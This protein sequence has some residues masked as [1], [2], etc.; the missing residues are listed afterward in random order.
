MMPSGVASMNLGFTLFLAAAL[1]SG[2]PDW[3]QGS[4]VSLT[5][6]AASVKPAGPVAPGELGMR[7][8][9]GTDDPGRI[10][11]SRA[12]L[13]DL[14]CRA[15]DVWPDQISGPAWIN[16]RSAY[17]YRID[18]TLPPNTN[19][20]QFRVMLQNLLAERFHLRIHRETK[21]I[22]GY[23]LVVASGGPKLKEWIPPTNAG[24]AK[25]SVDGNG[26]LKL[27]P[28][29]TMGLALPKGGGVAPIRMTHRETMAMFC[30]NLGTD[31]N[32]SNGMPV[33]GPRTRVIDK[34]GLTG[35]YEF[36]LEFAGSMRS[37]RT[38]PFAPA[39]GEPDVTPASDPAGAPDIFTAVEK[40]LGL[41]LVK[42]RDIPV[43]M[44]MVASADKVP[45]AN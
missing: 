1:A 38:M 23:E 4:D 15:Y 30:Q 41:K 12:T 35:T 39:G 9:P 32:I 31:I 21:T 27:P 36:T 7:G 3:A 42:V 37:P 44:V 34:T 22:P 10:T 29:A 25:P 2:T 18:A 5:F 24:P 16:D 45:T 13:S 6:E 8:G 28:G 20:G 14:L 17:A 40:Q 26:F 33:T 43:D 11:F 19:A